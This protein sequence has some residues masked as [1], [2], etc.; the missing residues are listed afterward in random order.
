MASQDFLKSLIKGQILHSTVEEKQ[1]DLGILCNF[2]GQLLRI[3]NYT[4]KAFEK[5]QAVRL[6]VKST[7]PLEFQIFESQSPKFQRVV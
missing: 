4:G 1:S 6:Q 5:G 3:S 2:N 7:D